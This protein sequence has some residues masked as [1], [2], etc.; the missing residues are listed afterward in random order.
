[1]DSSHPLILATPISGPRQQICSAASDARQLFVD[2]FQNTPTIFAAA[3]D[4]IKQVL[5]SSEWWGSVPSR[6]V[7]CR[8][9]GDE[10]DVDDRHLET[11]PRE[12]R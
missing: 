11:E 10:G 12:T 3:I 2:H 7:P 4:Y 9:R 1:M 6:I 5:F 8:G